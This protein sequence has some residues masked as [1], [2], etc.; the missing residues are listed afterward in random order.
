M[1]QAQSCKVEDI[2][3]DSS[4]NTPTQSRILGAKYSIISYALC[5]SICDK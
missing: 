4:E 2:N 3:Y 1:V 5:I